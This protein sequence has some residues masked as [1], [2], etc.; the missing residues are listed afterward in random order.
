M[1]EIRKQVMAQIITF[2]QAAEKR[3]VDPYAATEAAFPS[4][5][6][7]VVA[8][9]YVELGE[10]KTEAWWESIE[11]TIDGELVERALTAPRVGGR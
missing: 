3:G 8:L 5:P 1:S 2:M 6:T 11:K 4:I 7:E 9:A 10:R